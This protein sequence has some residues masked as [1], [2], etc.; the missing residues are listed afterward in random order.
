LRR[1]L[2]H[3]T[4]RGA[5][6]FYAA[7]ICCFFC[8][9]VIP[10]L[11]CNGGSFPEGKEHSILQR[12]DSSEILRFHVRADSNNFSDQ[13]VKNEVASRILELY[14]PAWRECGSKTELYC[15]LAE[16]QKAMAETAQLVLQEHGFEQDVAVRLERSIFPARLYEDKYYPSGEYEALV[17]VIGAGKG[18]NW[19]CVIF[20]PLCFNVFPAP[21]VVTEQGEPVTPA[22]EREENGTDK[23]AAGDDN[24]WRFWIV[25]YM[26]GV[27]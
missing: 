7:C 10:P 21:A 25:D 13:Q 20:P 17:V 23:E 24:K 27:K 26:R 3:S 9:F 11:P 8:L 16:E 2:M 19:W 18:E 6:Y 22:A 15:L 12:E 5:L 1:L 4:C 14:S